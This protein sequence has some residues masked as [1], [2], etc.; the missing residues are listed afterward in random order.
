MSFSD[1]LLA[2]LSSYSGGYRLMRARMH[3]Y[4]GPARGTRQGRREVSD[5][6]MR[7]TLSR[8]K[9]RGF[10]QHKDGRWSIGELG[11]RYLR[12]RAE[13]AQNTQKKKAI[14][15]AFDIPERKKLNRNWLRNELISF[16]FEMLQKSVWFG[17]APLSEEFIRSLGER[18]LL[19]H[20]KFF[21]AKEAE[22]V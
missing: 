9:R 7:V 13:K 19:P 20:L 18:G 11:R 16:G 6:V 1:D 15:V 17:P 3:G 8:L 22:V 4:T 12:L 10:V 14:I 5:A 21:E 2:V